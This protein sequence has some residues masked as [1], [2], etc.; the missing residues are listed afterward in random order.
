MIIQ[1][2]GRPSPGLLQ[3]DPAIDSNQIIKVYPTD[4]PLP[5]DPTKNRYGENTFAAV[6]DGYTRLQ[7]QGNYGP[8][9]LVL[10]SRIYA[11]TYAPLATTL[12]MPADRIKPFVTDIENN[13][14]FYGTGTLPILEEEIPTG[15]LVSIGGNS[16][17][18]VIKK[19][20]TVSQL[21]YVTGFYPFQVTA[22]FAVRIKV[23]SAFIR[24]EFQP[25]S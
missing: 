4:V 25:T 22:Q 21:P 24:F 2:L 14:R 1:Q 8:Y 6:S 15:I 19:P 17:D 10:H 12:I 23:T 16:V 9:A 18:L 13:V 5:N 7:D 20:P 3:F 11:D